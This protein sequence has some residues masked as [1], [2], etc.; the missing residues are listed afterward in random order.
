MRTE[1]ELGELKKILSD[2]Y[3]NKLAFEI[4]KGNDCRQVN[5]KNKKNGNFTILG[6]CS[7]GTYYGLSCFVF[8]NSNDTIRL[9]YSFDSCGFDDIYTKISPHDASLYNIRA[10]LN[11]LYIYKIAAVLKDHEV[12]NYFFNSKNL[13]KITSAL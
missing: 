10:I 4:G 5:L 13:N 11:W 2:I 9:G 1:I 12:I 8:I 6:G 7:D 3:S